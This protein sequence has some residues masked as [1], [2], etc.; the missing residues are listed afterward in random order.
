ML[1]VVAVGEYVMKLS[2]RKTGA[3]LSYIGLLAST[4]VSIVNVP[5]FIHFIGV[6][7]YGLYNTIGSLIT[8]FTALDFG[9]PATI[10]FFYSKYKAKN[11]QV[12]MENTLAI[13][14]RIFVFITVTLLLVGGGL[15]SQ[16]DNIYATSLTFDQL[17]KA[18]QIY[19]IFLINVVFTVP[20][21][22]INA[23]II[24]YEKFIF[25]KSLDIF[26]ILGQ[27]ACIFLAINRFPSALY[28]VAVQTVFNLV[29]VVVRVIYCF[30]ELKVKIKLHF[31]DSNLFWAILKYSFFIFL[32]VIV[33]QLFWRSNLLILGTVGNSAEVAA[34]S[35]AFQI[36][37]NY[38]T[39]SNAI[40]GVFLPGITAMVSKGASDK[41]LSSVFTKV[42]RLQFLLL[43]CILTGF[44]LF[45]K[46]FISL[47]S[48]GKQEFSDSYLVTLTLI[49]PM[50]I[51]LVQS[52]A[53]IILQAVNKFYFRVIVFLIF[54]VLSIF[55]AVP[56]AKS[57][58]CVG[59]ALAT[60][61]GYIPMLIVL[62]VF[63]A[64]NV[65]L[66]IRDFWR[67][68]FSMCVPLAF[69]FAVG[70]LIKLICIP[71]ATVDLLVKIILYMM[72]YVPVMW[73][74]AMNEYEKALIKKPL[75]KILGKITI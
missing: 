37:Y 50:T 8:Y 55:L 74:F 48:L 69:C 15:Y 13:C 7:E 64:K 61:V 66:D 67:Q 23:I 56:L 47:W 45:G 6:E 17:I 25:L 63:Y 3:I 31:F 53:Q 59:C 43:S 75:N 27:A 22:T 4:I 62:N 68:I 29:T 35:I 39:L 21:Q 49:V 24:A 2:E 11:D 1:C 28:V 32:N 41:D 42:G 16:L 12:S 10:V 54:N 51:D 14:S 70:F 65:K 72:L 46:Q 58:G 20:F 34:Y 60:I 71:I 36:A 19:I 38:T 40:K 33:D 57:Y 52:L 26:I 5:L 9:I 18:K 44:M 73:K 30:R